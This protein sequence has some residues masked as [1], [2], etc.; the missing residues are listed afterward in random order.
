MKVENDASR[1]KQN[2]REKIYRAIATKNVVYLLSFLDD[3]LTTVINVL[4][5]TLMNKS[6]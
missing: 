4:S 3:Q 2:L 6:E 1:E 5:L